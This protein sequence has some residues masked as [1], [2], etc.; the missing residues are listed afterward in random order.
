MS[1]C[2]CV[3]YYGRCPKLGYNNER[4][5]PLIFYILRLFGFGADSQSGFDDLID[6]DVDVETERKR[7]L[8]GGD[9]Q[10]DRGQK[11]DV[12]QVENFILLYII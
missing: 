7:V 4:H 8:Q 2:L 12:L 9:A 1:F 6:L 10:V 3:T 11:T 5:F